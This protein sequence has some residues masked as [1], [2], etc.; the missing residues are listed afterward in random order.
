MLCGGYRGA[1]RFD[2]QARADVQVG[3]MLAERCGHLIEAIDRN[4]VVVLPE[5]GAPASSMR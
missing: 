2:R 4:P 1:D 3:P 5:D